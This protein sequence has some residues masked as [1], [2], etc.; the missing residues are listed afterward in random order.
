[1]YSIFLLFYLYNLCYV[2]MFMMYYE[3]HHNVYIC[4]SIRWAVVAPYLYT[5]L[6]SLSVKARIFAMHFGLDF[7]HVIRG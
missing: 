2:S 4:V 5:Y 7:L 1:M 6:L 3:M